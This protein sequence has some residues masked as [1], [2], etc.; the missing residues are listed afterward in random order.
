VALLSV[1][2]VL[3]IAL[4]VVS[5]SHVALS[6]V[7]GAATD[8]VQ[9][10]RRLRPVGLLA[11]ASPIVAGLTVL[12]GLILTWDHGRFDQAWIVASLLLVLVLA[13]NAP[14][15]QG[16]HLRRFEHALT[17]TP[18][19]PVPA[20]LRMLQENVPLRAGQRLAPCLQLGIIVLMVERPGAAGSTAVCLVLVVV[21]A[22]LVVVQRRRAARF[23]APPVTVSS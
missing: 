5:V 8:T 23:S 4:M 21:A 11:V 18:S 19:G 15:V 1:H 17:R 3:A 6:E 16:P 10:R 9:L 14:V 2:V 7:A 12:S 22:L 13:V 20:E